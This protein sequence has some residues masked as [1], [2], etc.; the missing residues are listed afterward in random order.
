ML[1]G[2]QSNVTDVLRQF[3]NLAITVFVPKSLIITTKVNVSIMII[4]VLKVYTSSKVN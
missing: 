2:I 3:E 4:N 1:V